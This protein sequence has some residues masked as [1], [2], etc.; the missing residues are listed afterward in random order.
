[1]E[2]TFQHPPRARYI[3]LLALSVLGI[4]V[5]FYRHV[6]NWSWIDALYFSVIT[7]ATVGYGD[8]V[9]TTDLG[10][11]FT[12]FY[13]VIGIGIFAA[14]ANFLLKRATVKRLQKRDNDMKKKLHEDK[15]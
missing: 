8:L 1:M 9:P 13:V 4:G 5:I 12:V 3:A 10:K 15:H 7:L 14:S 2:P 6:E 11:L